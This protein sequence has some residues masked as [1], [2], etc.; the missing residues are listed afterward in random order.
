VLDRSPVHAVV[1]RQG[2]GPQQFE[3]PDVPWLDRNL[4]A[5]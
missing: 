2:G 5:P 1:V 3:S 4:L